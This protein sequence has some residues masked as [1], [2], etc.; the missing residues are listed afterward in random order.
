ML[1]DCPGSI[2]AGEVELSGVRVRNVE[3][4][5]GVEWGVAGK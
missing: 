2:F 3:A 4:G 1:R 5:A